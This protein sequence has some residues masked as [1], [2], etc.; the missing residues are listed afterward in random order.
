MVDFCFLHI[1]SSTQKS[2]NTT[3]T[4]VVPGSLFSTAVCF[5][6]VTG[7]TVI[8]PLTSN[9]KGKPSIRYIYFDQ[10]NMNAV[11]TNNRKCGQKTL[12]S[13][14]GFDGYKHVIWNLV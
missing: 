8:Q 14:L 1:A 10:L 3:G 6:L 12:I 4:R 13:A 7:N 2:E 11:V 9:N 5:I